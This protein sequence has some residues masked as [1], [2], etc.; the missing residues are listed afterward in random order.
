MPA[1]TTEREGEGGRVPM[2]I[3]G[4]VYLFFFDSPGSRLL[5]VSDH[6]IFGICH[7]LVCSGH[8]DI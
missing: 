8:A 5:N 6:Y 7:L 3:D 1:A 2:S 4:W